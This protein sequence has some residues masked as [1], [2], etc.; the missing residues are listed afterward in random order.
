LA[1][2]EIYVYDSRS[3]RL[4]YPTNIAPAFLPEFST[5]SAYATI[6]PG[7]PLDLSST[8]KE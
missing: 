6:D 3:V 2:I 8:L 1:D 5:I 7:G 4:H